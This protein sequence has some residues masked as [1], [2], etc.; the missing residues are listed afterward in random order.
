MLS[1]KRLFLIFSFF[2]FALILLLARL[3]FIQIFKSSRYLSIAQSQSRVII[4]M[5]PARGRVLDVKGKD[6][7]LDVPGIALRRGA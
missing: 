1:K 6:L 2:I 3:G 4:E 5:Q 7:A